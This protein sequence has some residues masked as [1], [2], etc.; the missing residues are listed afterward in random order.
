M[1]CH[2][3]RS[4]ASRANTD[5][6]NLKES[7][8]KS[9]MFSPTAQH[10]VLHTMHIGAVKG[11]IPFDL[12]NRVAIPAIP[13]ILARLLAGGIVESR[14][15]VALNPTRADRRPARLKSTFE[16]ANGLTS[17]PATRAAIR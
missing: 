5:R 3:E 15:Y 9:L 13:A 10:R 4:S 6:A 7:I 1:K 16:P 14:E 17:P 11:K 8:T 12:V 2:K